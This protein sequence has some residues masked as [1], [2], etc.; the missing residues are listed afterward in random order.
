MGDGRAE[1]LSAIGDGEQAAISPMPDVDGTHVH[2]FESSQ[3]GSYVGNLVYFSKRKAIE[4]VWGSYF[5]S[6]TL[7]SYVKSM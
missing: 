6:L 7:V 4:W 1:G 2:I 5:I 3:L